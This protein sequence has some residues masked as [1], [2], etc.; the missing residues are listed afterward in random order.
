MGRHAGYIALHSGIA[1]GA[2][3][4]LIPEDEVTVEEVIASLSEKEKRK[5]LVNL[6]VVAEGHSSGGAMKVAKAVK[7]HLPNLD[8]RGNDP[9]TYSKRR[10]SYLYRSS[11]C[12]PYGLSFSGKF[13]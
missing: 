9:G 5:K 6:V 4:I 12:K 3:N 11:Y 8:T 1:T 10:L 13:N 7:E 2:E